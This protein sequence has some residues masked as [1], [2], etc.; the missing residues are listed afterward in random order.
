MRHCSRPRPL[1]MDRRVWPSFFL[2]RLRRRQANVEA[3]LGPSQRLTGTV[4]RR[5]PAA[6]NGRRRGTK[7]FLG[8]GERFPQ[9]R[10][11]RP[12]LFSA[13]PVEVFGAASIADTVI[14]DKP[15]TRMQTLGLVNPSRTHRKRRNYSSELRGAPIDFRGHRWVSCT[16]REATSCQSD[17][18]SGGSKLPNPKITSLIPANACNSSIAI[19]CN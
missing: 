6:L 4:A 19:E 14:A 16:Y 12:K 1:G 17:S 8:R 9:S 2:C 7:D 15:S 10:R 18:S 13:D 3:A 5:D 11:T